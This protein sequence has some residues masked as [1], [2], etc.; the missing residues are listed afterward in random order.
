MMW[1]ALGQQF[2][3]TGLVVGFRPGPQTQRCGVGIYDR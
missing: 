1:R 2:P 3:G